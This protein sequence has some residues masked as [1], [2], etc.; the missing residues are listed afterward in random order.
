MQAV[1]SVDIES[2]R[3]TLGGNETV[4]YDQLILAPGGIPR[5]LPVECAM[6]ENVFTFRGVEDAKKVNLGAEMILV[7]LASSTEVYPSLCV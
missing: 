1:T 4:A 3:V 7:S 5:R 6:L 2:R